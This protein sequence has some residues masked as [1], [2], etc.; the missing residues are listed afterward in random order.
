MR[1]R[2]AN[3]F[4]PQ[5]M[6]SKESVPTAIQY[7]GKWGKWWPKAARK[8]SSEELYLIIIIMIIIII[9]IIII[10]I[11]I[12]IIIIIIKYLYSAQ[13]TICPWRFTLK[14]IFK[15]AKKFYDT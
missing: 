1:T 3:Q 11:I 7:E 2:K 13:S 12:I 10:M 8:G 15:K 6:I 5:A 9:I 14:K 4:Y